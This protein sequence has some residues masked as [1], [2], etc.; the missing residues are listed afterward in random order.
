MAHCNPEYY[1]DVIGLARPQ[2]A[3]I[4]VEYNVCFPDPH[5]CLR[6]CVPQQET[7]YETSYLSRDVVRELIV[8]HTGIRM[9]LATAAVVEDSLTAV[10]RP[11]GW[12]EAA[13]RRWHSDWD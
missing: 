4:V 8:D 5:M 12:P 1:Y 2:R 9:P 3:S 10:T 11:A 6:A 7:Y 13:S